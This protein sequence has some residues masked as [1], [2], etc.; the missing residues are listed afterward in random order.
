MQCGCEDQHRHLPE[1]LKLPASISLRD[2]G[3]SLSESDQAETDFSELCNELSYTLQL[4]GTDSAKTIGKRISDPSQ[5]A[6]SPEDHQAT[7][8]LTEDENDVAQKSR[9]SQKSNEVKLSTEGST[10]PQACSYRYPEDMPFIDDKDGCQATDSVIATAKCSSMKPI[11]M[12]VTKTILTPSDSFPMVCDSTGRYYNSS[13]ITPDSE[14]FIVRENTSYT[15]TSKMISSRH[16]LP[17]PDLT[18]QF[19][20]L[21]PDSDSSENPFYSLDSWMFND[22]ITRLSSPES[23]MSI[24]DYR[25]MSPDSPTWTKDFPGWRHRLSPRSDAWSSPEVTTDCNESKSQPHQSHKEERYTQFVTKD[26]PTTLDS[27]VKNRPLSTKSHIH[28]YNENIPKVRATSPGT[29]EIE[30]DEF[31]LEDISPDSRASSPDST[32]SIHEYGSSD[33]E[34]RPS[35]RE[36]Q[37][38]LCS[39]SFLELVLSEPIR[40]QLTSQYCDYYLQYSE[41]N[42]PSPLMTSSPHDAVCSNKVSQGR[43]FTAKFLTSNQNPPVSQE[44]LATKAYLPSHVLVSPNKDIKS[45][46]WQYSGHALS[47]PCQRGINPIDKEREPLQTKAFSAEPYLTHVKSIQSEHSEGSNSQIVQTLS[48]EPPR[49]EEGIS[50]PFLDYW[51]SQLKPQSSDYTSSPSQSNNDLTN[52]NFQESTS[53]DCKKECPKL[54][55]IT[56]YERQSPELCHMLKKESS[57]EPIIF[58]LAERPKYILKFA[59][60]GTPISHF[61]TTYLEKAKTNCNYTQLEDDIN[62]LRLTLDPPTRF[63]GPFYNDVC[64]EN[65]L[66]KIKQASAMEQLLTSFGTSSQESV[67]SIDQHFLSPEITFGQV[68]GQQCDYYLAY[69]ELRPV[70][71]LSTLSYVEYSKFSVKESFNNNTQDS[72]DELTLQADTKSSNVAGTASRP[73]SIGEPL[74][75]ADV[76]R[77][78]PGKKQ[79]NALRKLKSSVVRPFNL[80][81]LTSDEEF[82]L[83]YRDKF[84]DEFRPQSPESVLSQSELRPLSP[85][86]AVPQFRSPY[87]SYDVDMLRHRSYTPDSILSDWDDTGLCL[88]ALFDETRPESPQSVLSDYE[89]NRLFN[90]RAL[91]PESVSSDFDLSLLQNWLSDFRASSPESVASTQEHCLSPGIRFPQMNNKH[92]NYYL[93]Y[94]ED[95]PMSPLSTLSDVE[96]SK[97]CL[98]EL[99]DDSRAGSPDSLTLGTPPNITNKA[100]TSLPLSA[101]RYLTYADIVRGKA[102]QNQAHDMCHSKSSGVTPSHLPSLPSDDEFY[103]DQC[104]DEFRPQSPES[105]VSQ[106]ELRPLSPDSP[107]PQFRCPYYNS[108]IE[109]LRHRSYTPESIHSDWDDT[110]LCLEALFDETRPESPQSVLSDFEIDRLFKSRAL[111]PESVSSDFDFSLLQNW[112]SDFRASSPESV[113]STEEHC[114]SQRIQFPQMNNQHCHYYLEYTEDRPMSP[115]STLSDVEYSTF[116][117]EELIDDNRA[118]S[119]DSLTLGTQPNITNKAVTS[120]PLSAGRYLTYADIVRGNTQNNQAHDLCHIKS[121][122]VRPSYLASLPSDEEFYIDHCS[123]EFRPQSPES[124]VSQ[125]ELRPLSPDSPV[126]QFRCPYYNSN[127]ELLRHRSYTP[128]SIHSDWDDTGLCLEALF[129]KTRPESPQSVLS[130]FVIDRL[131]SSRAL[132]PESVSSDFDFS[133]L[134]SWLSDFRASSPE[135]VASTEEQ[136]FSLEIKFAPMNN[137]HCNYYLE[138]TEDKPGSPLSTLSDVE[139]S[140]FCLEELFDDNR[141]DSPDS[142]T[143]GTQPNITNKAV[144]SLPLSAGR[145][146]KY[147]D[148]VRGNTQN[149]QAHDLCHIKSSRVRPSYLASLPS[150]EEFYI[151]HCIDEFRPQ[152]PESVVSQS[153]LRP[154]SPDS[155]VP[156]F[157]CPLFSYDQ[158]LLRHRSYTPESIHSDWDDTGLCLEALFDETRPES[159]QSV[160]SDFEIDRLFSSRAFSPESVSSDFDFSLLQSWLSDFRASS[161]ESVASTEEHCLSPGIRFPQMNNKHCNYYLE[162][163]EDRPMSPLSTLSDVEYSKFCLEELFDDSRAGSPDSLTLGTPP[164]ITNKA[165]TSLPLS[166][167][168][169]LT[170]AD[171][172]RGKAQKNQA[173]DMCHSKSSGVRPSHLPSLPS[174]DE[175]YIDHCIDEFRPQSPESVVSQSE[176]RPLSPDSPV[177]QFRCPYYNS[178]IELLRHRSYTPESIHSDWDDTGL[179]LEALF[180]ETRP[181]SPQS[182]LSDFVIDRLFSSRALSPESVSSDF[183]FSLL[184]SWLSD[185]RTSS[186]ESV[187]SAEEQCFSLEIKFAPMNNQHCHHYLEYTEDRPMSPLSTLSDVEYSTFCLE[188]LIDDNRADSPDSLTLGTQPNI[189]NKAVTSLPLSAGRYLKYADIVRGNTQNNQAHDLCHIKSSRVRPSYLASLPSDEE[190]YIDHCIDEFRPQSPESVVSQSELRPLS[191]DS[192]VPEFRCPLFSYDQQLLRHRSYTPESIHSDWD[193]TGLCLE[194]LFDETRPESPQSVLSDFEIDRLFSSRAF[195]P[196]SVSSDFDFSLLQSWLSDFRASS[197]ESVASTEENCLSPGIRFPQMNNKH[198]NYYLEYSEDRPMSPLSTLSDV[199]YS[200][201]C[202]EELFDDSRAGSPDSL[203]LGTP[204]NITNK[205]VTSLPLSAGRYLTYADIV[206]GK[207]QKNQA[208]D[209]CHSKSSGVR[210]SHLPSLPSDDEFY[211]DH[212]IDEFRPQSPESVVSQSEL[213]PLSPDSPVPQF[214]C[215]YYN[216][217]IELLRH[218]SYT[219]ESIHSDWDDT[220]LCLE[221]L[222]DKTRPESP[223]SV[224]SDFVIDRL[225]SSR[226]LSPES[227]SSDFDFSLLQNWLSD[228]RTSSPESVASA[229]EQCF[230]LEIK[231]APMNNQH[232][233]YYLEYT[234]DRPMSPLSTLSDVEYSTFCLEELI[235]DNRADSPDSLTLGTQ[236]NITNKAVTSLPLSAGRYLKYADIVRGNTQNNQAHDLCHIKSSRVRPSYLPSLPSDEEFYIDHCIDE[237]RPQSPESVVSQSELRPLSPD[238]P[239]PEFRCPLFSYDQQLL[240]HRSYTPESIHSDWDDTGLCLEALFDETRPESPQ[241]VLTDFE[242]DRLF[243]SRAFSPESVSSD[244]DFSLLQSW[245]SDFRA[246]S[247]ESVASTEEHCLS[248]GIRFPQMNKKHCNYY[249]EYSEDRPMSPLSTLSDVEYSK[250]CL[251]ELFD[252]SR[253][254]SPDSLTLGTPPNITNKAVTSLPLSAGRYLTYADIVRGKAQKNQAHDMCHSKSSG[255]RPSHLPSLPSDDEFYIDHCI[256]EFRPQSPES[257]VSQSELRPLSPDSPVPQFRCPYYNSNIELLRHRSYTPESI[258]SDW[259][260]TGL[261]LEALFDETRPESPQSVLSDFVIDRLF[262]SRALSP[263]SVSSDFDFS[264]LHSLL[265]DFR[266]SSPES[267]ASTEEQY[268]SL[269]FKFAPMNNQHCHYYL[270]YTEDRPMSPLSTLSDVE[271]STFCLEELI[272]DNRADSPDSLTLG[273][274]PNITN[275]AVTSLPLSAGRYLKYADIVRGNTQNNQAHDLCH[276]KSSRVRPSYLPSLPSDEEFYIDHCIDEF[277]PQ[278]P[279][280]VVSQSELRPLSPDSPV[281]EFRCP[282]FSYDQQLLRHRSYTPESLHSDWDDTGLCLEALFDETRPESPQSVLTDFEIDRLFSS[283]AF[284]PESVSSDFD[285]SLLQSWLSDFRASSP[286][287]VAST[288]EHCLSPGIRFPQMN[289]KHCNYYLEYSEDRPMSPLSTLSDVEYSKFCLEELFDDSRA[290]SPDSLTLG[291]PPNITNK[292]VTSLPLSAGRYLTYADIVRGKAQKNQAHDMCHSKSSGVRPSHL[293]SLPSDDEFYIDHCIDEFRP[294][295][296]ESVVSQSELRPLSPDSPVPQFRCPYYN[297]NIELLR[298]RS[299]TPESIH[300]DWDDTGLCLEALFD[301]TRPESPQSVLSDFVIDRLFSSRAL[302]PESVS[303]DFDFSLLHSLLSD[304]RASSPESVASTEEQYLSLEF[305]FAPMNNQHCHYYLKYSEDR[306]M[307]PLSTLSD[308]EYSTFC[309]EEFFDDSRADSPDSLTLGTQPNITNKA[310]TSLPL[311]AGRYLTYADIVQGNTQKKQAHDLCHI[312]SSGVRPSYLPSLPSD[313]EFYIDHCIDE[314]RPQSPESVVSQSELRPLSPDSPVPQFRCPYYNSNIELLRHRSYTPESIH[315][316]WDDTGLCLEALFDETRPESPQS[317]LSDFEI[318]RLFQSRALSPES[319]SSDFDFSLLQNWLSDFRASSPESVV[320]TEEHCLSPRIK[321]PQMNNQHCNYYLEYTEDKPGSPL[322]TLSDVEYSTFCLEELFDDNRADTPDSLTLGTQPNITNKAVT[323]LPLSAGRYLTYADIVRGNTQNNQAHDLCHITSSRV[324]LSYLPSLPSDEEFYIDHCI[325]EFR[326][327][328]PESVVSQSELR[329][330]SPDSPVPQFGCPLFSYDRELLRHRSYTPESIHSDWDDTGLCLEALFDETRPESPQSVLSDFEIDRLF[331]S[332][333]LSPESVSSD[334]DFSLLQNWLSDFRA[335]SP[336][337]VVSTEEHCLSQRIQFPQMNNQHCNYYLEYTEDKPGSPL[338]TLSDVEYSTFCLEELFDDNRADTPDSLTLG[339]QPNIT[340]KAV[341][342]LPLS[343][344]RYLTYA[345]IV[346]G[347]TQNNQAHDLCH[348]TSS[349]VRPSYLPSL[350]SDEEFYIDHCINEFRPQSPESVVSQSELRPL[351][352]DSPVPQFGCPLF[353]YD[354]ELLRHRSYTPESIHSD[355]DDTGLCLEALFDETRPESP[356]SVLSDFEIDRLFSS[357]ALSPES[358]SSDFDLSLLQ[359]WLSDFR[360]SSPE[361]VALTEEQYFSL[362]IKFAPMNNQHCHYYL[363][364]SEDRPI[365]PLSTLSDVE[366]S[367]FC[368]EELFDDNRANSPDSLTLGSEPS[369]TNIAVTSLPLSAGRYLRYEDV[370]QGFKQENQASCI[371]KTFDLRSFYLPSISPHEELTFFSIDH[372]IDEFRPQSPESVVSQSELRPLSPDSPVPQFRYPYFSYDSELLRHRSYTP[373]SVLSDWD[374]TGLC[375]EALF[376]ETRPESP[377]SVLSD[378]EIDRLF[379][380]RALS[381]ESVSS[382]F[383]FSL[384]QN[385]LSD[386]RASSPESVVSTEEHCLSPRIKFP[387]MNN[388]HCNYY[389]EYTEDK[390]GSPLSTLSDVEYS[391]FCLEE[392]FDD[393]RADTPDSLTLGTQPNITNKAVTSLPLSAGRYLTYADIVRGNTQNNQAHDLC[394]I[395]SSSVRPSYL[396]SLPS[397]EEFY[398]DHCIDEFRPQSPESVVSQS[399]LRPLS[400]DSPVP[401]FGCPL[402]SYDRELLRHRSYTPESIHSDWDDTGLCLEALFD[403]T[404]PESP[405]SVLSDFEIDRLFKS[406]A[407]SPESVSSDFDFSLLQNWLS[408]FRASSPESV[409]STEEHCLSPRIKFPQMNNQHCN[410]YLEYTEDKP[411]SPLSTLSD[412][413]YSTFCLDDFFDDSRADST[414]SLTLGTQPNITNKAVTSLPLSAGRYLTYADIVRGNTQNNQ[415]HD[416]CHIKSSGV[417]P[418]YLPSLPQ[419]EELYIDHCIDEFRPQSPESVVSQSELRPLSPDSPVPQ[420]GCPLFSYDRELLRHRSYTPESIHS[421]LDDTGLCLEALFDETRPESPQSVLSDFEI[422]RLFKSRALSPESVSSDFDFSL[423]QNWLSGFRASSPESVVSTEEHCLS[424]RIKFPQMNNQH[425]NYY[426]EYTEDKPGSPLSTLSDVEYS[427]FCLDDFFDDSRA[428]SPDSLTL[429]TQP[430]IT[431]KAVTSLPLSAGRYLTYADIVRGN[432]QK[433]QAHDLCHIKSSG[434]IPSYLPSLPSDEELYIDHC[435]DEFRPQSPESVVSQSELRPLSPDSPVPQFRCPF[436]SYD[437]EL[438]RHRS[439]TP[440]SI[441]SD[442]DDTDLCLEA[443]FDETRPESPQSVLSDFEIDRLFSSRALSPESVSS[444]FDFSLLPNWLSDFR[445]SS[446]ESVASTEEQYFSLGIPHSTELS[447]SVQKSERKLNQRKLV[448]CESMSLGSKPLIKEFRVGQK[449]LFNNL[450]SH[451]HD[452]LYKGE[453]SCSEICLVKSSLKKHSCFVK[454]TSLAQTDMSATTISDNISRLTHITSEDKRDDAI[455]GSFSPTGQSHLHIRSTTADT[456]S[457]SPQEQADES[458]LIETPLSSEC[459]PQSRETLQLDNQSPSNVTYMR[460]PSPESYSSYAEFTALSPLHLSENRSIQSD[461][462]PLERDCT[463]SCFDN[464]FVEIRPDSP[465]SIVLDYEFHESFNREPI[466]SDFAYTQS[467]LQHWLSELG[468]CTPQYLEGEL[469]EVLNQLP[470]GQSDPDATVSEDNKITSKQLSGTSLEHK[471]DPVYE[472]KCACDTK[473][474]SEEAADVLSEKASDQNKFEDLEVS[475]GNPP[476]PTKPC[477]F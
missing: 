278:S 361:S 394:H 283:R 318:D 393:N 310:V 308:V 252:D 421:D 59:N 172:V 340:N 61:K 287:S 31:L 417:I 279:E 26:E 137:Q 377:Q 240:R 433:K 216:S 413:E 10:K 382:D 135:S 213:R 355:W 210:P 260:D 129:D 378:Y 357:R 431:N 21:T 207:A 211:I 467:F 12:K 292:A 375:L 459:I 149:N 205:A 370:V 102:Q 76:V 349:R 109:L 288:E 206:R 306:P 326:P 244:F 134:Q 222:F 374:C 259:D 81:L 167:G 192:P 336:E 83:S 36:S 47:S 106:S 158:Q 72:P 356:Q 196:E 352:P 132:S 218:R 52:N 271:Y 3:P 105:I 253:A 161:P 316:D 380:S 454:L 255:V 270:E 170:Y 442:W 169:Y 245:L 18:Q 164:N 37:S 242:I 311:S 303:S 296:P 78:Y 139:Y 35:S 452:P 460:P 145:Y 294:Q 280:S 165:V 462:I 234:E 412:V 409:V 391:T 171:I 85:D 469:D 446:P 282:L 90:S 455:S 93:E 94:S 251:E 71:P 92:C 438:L 329:P 187:A 193:D 364:Y 475:M 435:I 65:T 232:C 32:T 29:S 312:K 88:E 402:F 258:H 163:S 408:G 247:P 246:S 96:Y 125:S 175:F 266:A 353:S 89:I 202:L 7:L 416:L 231:F 82:K 335:S 345:D 275:K 322:S 468:P 39:F 48:S 131:F 320:S 223:Q 262:S 49:A 333:A 28:E 388:Q 45:D 54:K 428:D 22:S 50:N 448:S 458:E 133:L 341:T 201:F 198:C 471:G 62:K 298:H 219:P 203:T 41:G 338:S 401:Q 453:C 405:Q 174:D 43:P 101:E 153:E 379:N 80:P 274:Q 151:D 221:A 474:Y 5:L 111:S 398:I 2:F 124:V 237:F 360:A 66:D 215:P 119:P 38:S 191:P 325:D 239:V 11:K 121:S 51:F 56:K 289:K 178:N 399:E 354:R 209:M 423:L 64:L 63:T 440:E 424:P 248:P 385:W 241:S 44:S 225:F 406:R 199:E 181:E 439:Y 24:T 186:P 314:F 250:F 307:S 73:L 40:A 461:F 249:L 69:S 457:T 46:Y 110:G 233:H 327:Q 384:L 99:F 173:H 150:D 330:L 321:F 146:L 220:G 447:S 426:L 84:I 411:G 53:L 347:N 363:E 372:F 337:S 297:S 315:S 414:D 383:D 263:E 57:P 344:G 27:L 404:R 328:S 272:D 148:I 67:E 429:G 227:V 291:T 70:S 74:T 97:F 473:N 463:D 157:R 180:D 304:F 217:N 400:P 25:A 113:V 197:P 301:E 143:L 194:A 229:E 368:L 144:T 155:P 147:A 136:C 1:I 386:F 285:F 243:S 128:E 91:S 346:R 236:P 305:K 100:V 30:C 441:H 456:I 34:C 415:A 276:I 104:I 138:Y 183:D 68:E 108:N 273:T 42:L 14:H 267:V 166:A 256:D 450:M 464:F 228:F 9:L 449:P 257:V 403:E 160:L 77:G 317:V 141:A 362:E 79:D 182:V 359:S 126:P 130:D 348:I 115:L 55:K 430:N 351:S 445:A 162:Y 419:D 208:H 395:T 466:T 295:S 339:T 19:S 331:K 332:R 6:L 188:E 369:I 269:E 235:D 302:S 443:L 334:F 422:D 177:P 373:D 8:A 313:E 33:R 122:R 324:R 451:L 376:D 179:C 397:D 390:P 290:G 190:F 176:L 117:L 224:L 444:D 343:A 156:E 472:E 152:S 127:I 418:S 293:P 436:F 189:T 387:Q 159:P 284:S 238:S 420:F 425:C 120:L 381:P 184:Q 60:E 185:F 16:F 168:R 112:L 371:V 23:V 75:Y 86:S 140:T 470:C 154:L 299:Y 367:T 95:R 477:H 20:P 407:L 319:V 365:S 214:R 226:A 261:C 195:S 103:I 427:T 15:S 204:P 281:P 358:V 268:L 200:K 17:I 87:F 13:F 366:Y 286:E 107:V 437:R 342:S 392:L 277:R 116:C 350:P 264:L 309:L 118:D 58:T 114:L 212:C 300:S 142:L 265:S 465:D 254:G 4:G 389:L 123:D 410:Y 230:S 432:T 434:V 476:C 98:E 323:S 396:P